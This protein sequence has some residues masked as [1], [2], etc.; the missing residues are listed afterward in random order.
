M[1]QKGWRK[2]TQISVE[3]IEN[4]HCCTGETGSSQVKASPRSGTLMSLIFQK[5]MR[6][7]G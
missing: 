6:G 2:Q 1:G 4:D 3:N 5:E 7:G